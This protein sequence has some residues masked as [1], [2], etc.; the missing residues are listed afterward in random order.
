MSTLEDVVYDLTEK[1]CE[2]LGLDK[3][4]VKNIVKFCILNHINSNKCIDK[5]MLT[6]SISDILE[7][8]IDDIDDIDDIL[9]HYFQIN[10]PT[11]KEI[12]HLATSLHINLVLFD[13]KSFESKDLTDKIIISQRVNF[14]YENKFE[15]N[16]REKL[17]E[18]I[19][20]KKLSQND[21]KELYRSFL[22]DFLYEIRKTN[23]D[24]NGEY[25]DNLNNYVKCKKFDDDFDKN[26]G[27]FLN[28]V[29]VNKE[30]Q[31]IF[32]SI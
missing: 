28:S 8:D 9:E 13:N 18:L 26:F 16:I 27:L 22:L 12:K 29:E 21:C 20:I 25:I 7:A 23:L 1:I 4:Q 11:T 15:D 17:Y 31:K 24:M 3:K 19:L 30:Y 2:N 6:E 10:H 5:F 32:N 14:I